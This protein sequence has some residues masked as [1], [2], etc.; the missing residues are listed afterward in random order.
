MPTHNGPKY[1]PSIMATKKWYNVLEQHQDVIKPSIMAHNKFALIINKSTN[2]IYQ[3]SRINAHKNL[4]N[5]HFKNMNT[6]N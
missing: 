3:L 4:P 5:E 6:V 1:M 2:L